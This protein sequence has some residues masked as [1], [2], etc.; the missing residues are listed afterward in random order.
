MSYN[1]FQRVRADENHSQ[2]NQIIKR[3]HSIYQRPNDIRSEFERDYTRLLHSNG[4]RRLKTKTQVFFATQNDHVCTRIEHV[5]HV[6][7]VSTTIGKAL[8]LNTE[9][10][11]SIAIG[12]DIGHAPFGHHG[13]SVLK[14]LA[15]ES[16][17]DG[18][19]W[20]EKNSLF[21]VDRIETL[22][23]EKGGD[24]NLNLTYA[25]RDG[26]ISHCGEVNE[27]AIFP[28]NEAIDLY[29]I[30]KPNQYQPF[31]WEGCVVKIA[32]KIAYLGRDIEDAISLKIFRMADYREL[33]RI[34]KDC[35]G[36]SSIREINNGILI[37]N[38]IIDLC[39]NSSPEKGIMFSDKYLKL[40]NEVKAFNYRAIYK[41]WRIEEFKKYATVVI[42]T[43]YNTL[44]KFYDE[45]DHQVRLGITQ[46]NFPLLSTTF[47]EW[48]V[49]YSDYDLKTKEKQKNHN[50]PVFYINEKDSFNKC[51]ISFIAGMTD[52]FALRIFKEIISF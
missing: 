23:D 7:S 45:K 33:D 22:T 10:I 19:F 46:D 36:D 14:R 34:L 40:I 41:Y 24:Q 16:I 6:V 13:E 37:H 38:F 31:T 49:K 8:G 26:I 9:L 43:I 47:K 32:D 2:W 27:N 35:L 25:V 44:T 30:E 50:E 51:C 1:Q 18:F 20:H 17:T 21:F 42:E 12:H 5:N 28:R 29:R 4:Y 39:E 15:K 3:E 11:S 48:L 52:Q